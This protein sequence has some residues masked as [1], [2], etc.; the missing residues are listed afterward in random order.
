MI[1]VTLENKSDNDDVNYNDDV[2]DNDDGDTVEIAYWVHQQ[3][4]LFY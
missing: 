3:L 2:N 1:I 4:S